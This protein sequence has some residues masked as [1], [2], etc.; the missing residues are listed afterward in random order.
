MFRHVSLISRT[1]FFPRRTN[2]HD[3]VSFR[4]WNAVLFSGQFEFYT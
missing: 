3:V 4:R 1:V 2:L